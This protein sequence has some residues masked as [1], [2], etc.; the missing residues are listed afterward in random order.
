MHLREVAM[1]RYP[2]AH[3]RHLADHKP[4]PK[5]QGIVTILRY[6]SSKRLAQLVCY[7]EGSRAHSPGWKWADGL[8]PPSR[9]GPKRLPDLEPHS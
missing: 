3:L 9:C 8:D 2:L 1:W 7:T 4:W 6:R 5:W